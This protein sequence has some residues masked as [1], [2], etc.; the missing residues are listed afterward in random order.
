MNQPSPLSESEQKLV[1]YLNRNHKRPEFAVAR[2]QQWHKLLAMLEKYA[3]S[4]P[5][6]TREKAAY[7][8]LA[9]AFQ[10]VAGGFLREPAI[11]NSD[12]LS[13][14]QKQ[15]LFGVCAMH[16]RQR[17]RLMANEKPAVGQRITAKFKPDTYLGKYGSWHTGSINLYANG[18]MFDTLGVGGISFD[19]IISW[20]PTLDEEPHDVEKRQRFEQF[21]LDHPDY[22]TQTA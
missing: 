16:D 8:Y 5:Q 17:A 22:L 15:D 12:M 14:A 18:P 11:A 2:R 21:A 1:D 6:L 19:D 9:T 10:L 20:V 3:Q 4:Q 13:K 7:Q